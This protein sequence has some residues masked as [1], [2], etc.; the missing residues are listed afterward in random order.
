MGKKENGRAGGGKE[1]Q[2]ERGKKTIE[3]GAARRRWPEVAEEGAPTSRRQRPPPPGRRA[4]AARSPLGSGRRPPSVSVSRI[5]RRSHRTR[6]GS[7]AVAP[8]HGCR[9]R[10]PLPAWEGTRATGARRT[11]PMRRHSPHAPLPRASPGHTPPRARARR[12]ALAPNREATTRRGTAPSRRGPRGPTDA[13]HPPRRPPRAV[14]FKLPPTT[15]AR[16]LGGGASARATG[17][18]VVD[19]LG[20]HHLGGAAA[21]GSRVRQRGARRGPCGCLARGTAGINRQM[22]VGVWLTGRLH[23]QHAGWDATWFQ[24]LYGDPLYFQTSW[25]RFVLLP[26]HVVFGPRHE[27]SVFSVKS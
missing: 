1:K 21:L 7:R 6:A 12:W 13:R 25:L 9:R 3:A 19:G 11:N 24:V 10:P 20:G 5:A 4:V 26:G 23:P 16:Q 27:H 17:S 22:W 8:P 15:T 18:K 2:G 14:L